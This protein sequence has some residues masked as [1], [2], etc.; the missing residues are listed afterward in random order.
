MTMVVAAQAFA[1]ATSLPALIVS[2]LCALAG[3][4]AR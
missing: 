4:S 3:I 2:T 1:A